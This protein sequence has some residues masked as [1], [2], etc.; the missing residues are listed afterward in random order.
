[1][2]QSEEYKTMFGGAATTEAPIDTPMDLEEDA[3]P[4]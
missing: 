3:L 4:F 1:M 2:V